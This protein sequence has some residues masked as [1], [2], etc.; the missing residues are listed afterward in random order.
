MAKMQAIPLTRTERTKLNAQKL[1]VILARALVKEQNGQPLTASEENLIAEL[2]RRRYERRRDKV[3]VLSDGSIVVSKTVDAE[4]VMDAMKA[5]GDF[6]DR[7]SQRKMAQR[8]VGSL[9]TVTAFKWMQESGL[10]VGTREFAQFAIKRIK[11][12]NT[13]RKFRVGH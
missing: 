11:N 7:H 3:E 10:K 9:D 13:Y 2:Y 1:R 4:P 8:I 12:D 6:I 5:Y